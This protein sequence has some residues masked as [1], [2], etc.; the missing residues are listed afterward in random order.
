[1]P[2]PL[3]AQQQGSWVLPDAGVGLVPRRRVGERR[4]A[5]VYK[6][7]EPQSEVAGELP[8]LLGELGAEVPDVVQVVLHG[9]GEVHQVVQVHGIVLHLPHLQLEGSL[10]ACAKREAVRVRGHQRA[11]GLKGWVSLSPLVTA[12]FFPETVRLWRNIFFLEVE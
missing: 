1:M 11:G 7:P 12:C 9:Q 3:N 4:D 5:F 6:G 2:P 8:H 10:V